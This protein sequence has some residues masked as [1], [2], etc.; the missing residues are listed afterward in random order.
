MNTESLRSIIN[1]ARLCKNSAVTLDPNY[2][3]SAALGEGWRP[4]LCSHFP[5]ILM[6]VA[7]RA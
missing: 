6:S 4:K 3:L 7:N 2:S 1:K 5:Y